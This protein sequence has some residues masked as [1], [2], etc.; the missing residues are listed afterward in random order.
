MGTSMR[1]SLRSRINRRQLLQAGSA[2]GAGLVAPAALSGVAGARQDTPSDQSGTFR[3]MS[4]E[5]EAEMRKWQRHI[6]TFFD[7]NYPNMEVQIDYG[8][9]WEEYWTKLQ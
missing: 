9:P 3:A 6:N 2:V 1:Q 8:I 5:T 4:W 7:T